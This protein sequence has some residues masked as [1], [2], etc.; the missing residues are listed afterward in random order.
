MEV[1]NGV[2]YTGVGTFVYKFD[3]TTWTDLTPNNPEG[4]RSMYVDKTDNIWFENWNNGVLKYENGNWIQHLSIIQNEA[5]PEGRMAFDFTK[6]QL[7]SGIYLV[8]LE[9]D[10]NIQTVKILVR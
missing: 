7:S 1:R 5:R 4:L 9:L 10:N 6:G 2:I 8:K 3:E